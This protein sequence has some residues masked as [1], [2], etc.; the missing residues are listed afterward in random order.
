M[1]DDP[2]GCTNPLGRVSG[3]Q[4]CFERHETTVI[5]ES[6]GVHEDLARLFELL[7]YD[8]VHFLEPSRKYI[9]RR[10]GADPCEPEEP[11]YTRRSEIAEPKGVACLSTFVTRKCEQQRGHPGRRCLRK[12]T[13]GRGYISVA[14]EANL[15][16]LKAYGA[17]ALSYLTPRVLGLIFAQIRRRRGKGETQARQDVGIFVANIASLWTKKKAELT[18][19]RSLVS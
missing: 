12:F 6:R 18:S 7:S 5:P 11:I 13:L 14:N 19:H 15:R 3:H 9:L 4:G 2:D 10:I 17:G 16:I 8:A 1:G